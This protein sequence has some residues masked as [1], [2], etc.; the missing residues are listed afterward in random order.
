MNRRDETT[1]FCS[2]ILLSTA[3]GGCGSSA[4]SGA[5]TNATGTTGM[6]GGGGAG[7]GGEPSTASGGVSGATITS[8]GGTSG[9]SGTSGIVTT[10]GGAPLLT[11]GAP[12]VSGSGGAPT[13]PPPPG[14]GGVV[15]SNPACTITS[16]TA[17]CNS[18]TIV[19]LT[20]G[21]DTRRIYWN[22]PAGTAP[23]GGWPAVVLFQG[24]V[25]GP[26]TS[27]NVALPR[28]TP[29]GGYN[30]VALIANLLDHGFV[31]VQPEAQGGLAWN[32]NDGSSYDT[33]PD[34]VFMPELLDD[35]TAGTF[36]S[37]DSKRL[38]ATGISSGGYMTSRMAVSY[39]GKFRALAIESASYATC[40]GPLCAIPSVLPSDH[41]PTLFLHGDLDT[42]V[43]IATAKAYYQALVSNG[44]ETQFIEDPAASHQWIDAAPTAVTDWFLRH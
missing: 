28:S 43:P 21:A 15:R 40:V 32:T 4:R 38:Y 14:D 20:N 17:Q 25:Y 9:I 18:Q 42:I 44:T 13:I 36:G 6:D 31:V 11:G 5:A 2:L 24:S 35:I 29:F 19:S 37:V 22:T 12:G 10:D 3:L 7:S 26:S 39:A 1:G 23:S 16:D 27:W 34:A 33:S 8:S 41:P 30:Q